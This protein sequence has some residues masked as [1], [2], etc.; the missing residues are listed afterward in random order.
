MLS[1]IR[2]LL[3]CVGL[4]VGV[5]ML[6]HVY[7]GCRPPNIEPPKFPIVMPAGSA[8]QPPFSDVLLYRREG[9]TVFSQEHRLYLSRSG[10]LHGVWLRDTDA[11]VTE[12]ASSKQLSAE[13]LDALKALL[14]NNDVCDLR[15][16]G[17]KNYGDKY[18]STL[19]L[20]WDG[21]ECTVVLYEHDWEQD[22]DAK[23]V[24]QALERLSAGRS[25]KPPDPAADR[26]ARLP[27]DA[28][29]RWSTSQ[30]F[31][32]SATLEIKKSGTASYRYTPSGLTK[33]GVPKQSGPVQISAQALASLREVLDKNDVCDLASGRNGIPE[34]GSAV[35]TVSWD[36]LRCSVRLWAGEWDASAASRAIRAAFEAIEAQVTK[37]PAAP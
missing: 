8:Y 4:A 34:E 12:K 37:G 30:A 36:G 5:A 15:S 17:E 23:N 22:P 20:S 14:E 11:G 29:V 9:S 27:A 10:Q 7:V 19:K 31:W 24:H 25:V 28:L 6:S 21:L 18:F 32:G 35:V 3:V 16:D 26:L 33:G 1:R 2:P 13:E